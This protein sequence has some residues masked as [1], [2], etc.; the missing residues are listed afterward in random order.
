MYLNNIIYELFN[1][2]LSSTLHFYYFRRSTYLKLQ[3]KIFNLMEF[4]IIIIHWYI[5]LKLK[6]I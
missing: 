2:L 6:I 3:K 1:Y 5:G 4:S